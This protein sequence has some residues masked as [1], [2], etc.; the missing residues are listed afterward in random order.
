MGLS[1]TKQKSTTA[2]TD[3]ARPQL[4]A[5]G[6]A[7]TTAYSGIQPTI[8][9][10]SSTLSAQL[11]GLADK[12][13]GSDPGLTAATDYNTDVLS[14]NYLG[15]SNPYLRA[16]ADET[17]GFTTN[18][19]NSAF[20]AAGRSTSPANQEALTRG[21]ASARNNLFATEYSN[22][23]NRMGQAAAL[24]PTLNSN[25]YTGLGAYLSAAQ[26]ATGIPLDAARAYSGGLG[27]LFSPFNTTTGTSSPSLGAI[28]AQ[29]GSNAAKAY[30]GGG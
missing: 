20:G 21:L 28:I 14:G 30:A 11:P 1:K 22:E 6:N 10:I 19:I 27:S 26:G 7:L 3:Y 2:P 8:Q 13:F 17:A 4:D 5:A 23:R 25:Q 29:I 18:R 12:A 24:A 9:N 15:E 16:I